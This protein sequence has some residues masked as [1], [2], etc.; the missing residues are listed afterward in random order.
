MIG[1]KKYP[2]VVM[3]TKGLLLVCASR[4]PSKCLFSSRRGIV[5]SKKGKL[6]PRA[7][8]I[9]MVL[10]LWGKK[11]ESDSGEEEFGKDSN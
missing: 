7:I 6:S 11:D 10:K 5:A 3:F 4:S 8:S 2:R 1:S 9:L